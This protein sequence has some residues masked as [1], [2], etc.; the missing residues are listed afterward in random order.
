MNAWKYVMLAS[1]GKYDEAQAKY[2]EA[3]VAEPYNR[4]SWAGLQRWAKATN[5]TLSHP[6]LDVPTNVTK[7]NDKQTTITLDPKM[8][9][10][11]E[12]GSAAWL[13]YGLERALW[14]SKKFAEQYPNERT[15]RHSLAEEAAALRLVIQSVKEQTKDKKNLTLNVSLQN[16]LKLDEAG[17]LEP[18]ILMARADDGIAVD[19]PAYLHTNREK[20]R[21]YVVEVV[22]SK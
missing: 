18:F 21:R 19:Y 12:D 9:G 5:A 1:Q 6:I 20:L 2:I 14:S 22:I 17:L 4:L 15:Y 8:V 3:V 13:A 7:T 11:K 10:N 16:L